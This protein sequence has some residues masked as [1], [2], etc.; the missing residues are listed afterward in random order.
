MITGAYK[1]TSALALDIEAYTIPFKQKLD[2][3]ISNALLRIVSNPVYAKIIDFRPKTQTYFSPLETLTN[4]YKRT[5]KGLISNIEQILPF[6]ASPWWT[7]PLI[8]IH[9]SKP[10]AEKAH[11]RLLNET[12]RKENQF[13]ICTD[14]SG[15]N[16]KIGAAAV[17][18]TNTWN[19]F[20]GLTHLFTVYS[21][22]LYGIS[23]AT[24]MS[25]ET[26]IEPKVVIIY[27]DSQAA[28]RTVS[29]PKN[30]S[31]QHIVQQIVSAID[32]IR[33]RGSTVEI[34]WVPAHIGFHGNEAADKSAKEATG[35]RLK[36]LRRGG[37]REE[38]ISST[39][40]KA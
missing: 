39:A 21:K 4:R 7:P 5:S 38:N 17:G 9:H 11:K 29:S 1:A 12:S 19:A 10:V 20:L 6:T 26:L 32:C 28:I 31:G 36:K 2:W 24:K 18:P 16:G 14:G 27:V 15:I 37:A 3:L 33:Q 13:L 23:L 25:L 40:V 35:W 30:K 8:M 22:E 34:H